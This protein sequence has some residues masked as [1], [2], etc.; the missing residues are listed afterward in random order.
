[1]A[2]NERNIDTLLKD[3]WNSFR[4]KLPTDISSLQEPK[5]ALEKFVK[6]NAKAVIQ[7]LQESGEA[8]MLL[9]KLTSTGSLNDEE[10]KKLKEQLTDI[11]KT[12]PALGIFALPGGMLLL[13]ILAKSLPWDLVPSAF[14]HA[15]D[16]EKTSDA[17]ADTVD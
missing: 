8:L 13:P 17:P 11:A 14:K 6:R 4:A 12:L 3:S 2:D 15:P 10:I 7:E 5:Q 1:M 16:E 9:W